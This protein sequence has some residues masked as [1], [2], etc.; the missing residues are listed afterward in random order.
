MVGRHEQC[1]AVRC[2]TGQFL[3]A[4]AACG[5]ANVFN[6]HRHPEFFR[7]LQP[8]R[9]AGQVGAATRRI[10]NDPADRF[11][12]IVVGLRGSRQGQR[13]R[14]GDHKRKLTSPKTSRRDTMQLLKNKGSLNGCGALD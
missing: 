13:Q 7:Q 12:R 6:H 3:R 8:Q 14:A 1:V 2:G 5:S 9:A 10:T 4:N 11:V